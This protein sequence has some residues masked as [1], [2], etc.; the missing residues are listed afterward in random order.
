MLENLF[1]SKILFN[2]LA[3]LFDNEG[4]SLSTSEII[5]LT[6]K[7]QT[8]VLR[9]LEKL[10]EWKIV[11]K[12]KKGNQNFYDL[13][14][15]YSFNKQLKELFIKYENENKPYIF[16]VEENA[17]A[18]LS[19]HYFIRGHEQDLSI[20]KGIL[21]VNPKIIYLF[22][23]NYF[24]CYIEKEQSERV[25]KDSLNK[26]LSD[27]SF[28]DDIIFTET[29][30]RGE[31]ALK[32]FQQFKK[33]NFKVKKNK[34]V[35][36][37]NTFID[38]IDT[39]I[40]LN[41]I[42][43]YDL[44]DAPYSGYLKNYLEKKIK[45]T[46]FRLNYLLEKLLMPEKLTMTQQLRIELLSLAIDFKKKKTNFEAKLKRIQQDW[47][48]INYGYRGPILELEYF[49]QIFNELINK[50]LKE[51]ETELKSLIN[52]EK[53]VSAEKE[54]IYRLLK[55]DKKHQDFI[56]AMSTLSYFKL[57]RKDTAFLVIFM[58][59]KI[60][61]Q[62]IKEVKRQDWLY[63]TQD[64][65]IDMLKG[66]RK[67]DNDF[68]HLLISRRKKCLSV[69]QGKT[70]LTGKE[71]DKFM[72]ENVQEEEEINTEN[73]KIK[74]LEGTTACLGRTGD[75]I[76]GKVKVINTS[77][78]MEKMEQGDILISYATTPDILPAMKKASAIVTEQGGITSHAAIVSRELNV[79]C[80]IG[81]K[82]ATKVFKDGDKVVMCPRHGNV[83]YQ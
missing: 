83:K 8:N 49:K 69:N 35:D 45:G 62:F 23:N 72:K 73:S 78:D 56:N 26:F 3:V 12:Q 22:K 44:L 41:H 74:L 38:I 43:V 77:E 48:W 6:G 15:Q 10:V 66:K 53:I 67:I 42:A 13:N 71:A 80:L 11:N 28:V 34:A 76:Y 46:D 55:I 50:S 81:V 18:L 52:N 1:S 60:A 64:E 37:M 16:I 47:Q 65:L 59:H 31:Q 21:N 39:Q 7:K 25:I 29:I 70:I 17:G 79:P 20:K 63:L 36:L 75:W 57:Y 54:K 68:K 32:L 14:K 5:Q 19:M 51:L 82:Y 24:W 30:K 40:S 4:K 9:E 33:S 2:I 27:P 61:E 58:T